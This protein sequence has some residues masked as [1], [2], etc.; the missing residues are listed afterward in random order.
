VGPTRGQ[1]RVNAASTQVNA[2]ST[3]GQRGDNAGSTWG[4]RGVNEGSTW[5]DAGS[6]QVNAGSTWGQPGVN[7]GSTQPG[8][9]PKSTRPGVNLRSTYTAQPFEL[10][11]RCP[12]QGVGGKV[13]P[14]HAAVQLSIPAPLQG[15]TTVH[16][17]AQPE[18]FLSQ[19]T[20]YTPPNIPNTPQRPPPDPL[21]ATPIL[22]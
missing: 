9:N 10:A 16:F 22:Q 3:W 12:L 2:G 21:H 14:H 13:A 4:Q 19:N 8:V 20:H 17:W 15:L 11:Q 18:P 5:V 1:R 6:T 7:P